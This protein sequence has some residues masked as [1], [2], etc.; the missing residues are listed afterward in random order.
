MLDEILDDIAKKYRLPI[1]QVKLI[2]SSTFKGVKYF[3]TNPMYSK[4]TIRLPGLG[5]I[6]M[7]ER[8]VRNHYKTDEVE[9]LKK[10][11]EQLATF[12]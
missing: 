7:T 6:M 1:E 12:A 3:T 2:Y 8:S 9:V 4:G 11:K 5:R 10:Y